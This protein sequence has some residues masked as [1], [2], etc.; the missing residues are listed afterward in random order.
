MKRDTDRREWKRLPLTIPVFIRGTDNNGK[1]F[2]DFTVALNVSGGGALLATRQ[3]LSRSA[4]LSLEIPSTPLP[5]S[6]QSASPRPLK[7]RVIRTA[8]KDSYNLYGL[9]FSRPLI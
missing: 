6:L 2:L 3:P 4:R 1:E 9:R 7:A 8:S 5:Q